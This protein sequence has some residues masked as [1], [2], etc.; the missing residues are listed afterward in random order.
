MIRAIRDMAAAW[1]LAGV[2]IGGIVGYALL[3]GPV[4]F[5]A[6]P[7]LRRVDVSIRGPSVDVPEGGVPLVEP[8]D[9][10][11]YYTT[12]DLFMERLE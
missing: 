4:S 6:S 8:Y 2:L 5:S 9:P 7:T 11:S 10:P 12:E 1:I 3:R